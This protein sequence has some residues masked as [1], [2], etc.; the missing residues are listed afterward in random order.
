MEEVRKV[1]Q[2]TF[3]KMHQF[4]KSNPI[5]WKQ[6][7]FKACGVDT[8]WDHVGVSRIDDAIRRL[9]SDG[10]LICSGHR[11]GYRQYMIVDVSRV[12]EILEV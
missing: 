4:M 10:H 7:L 9:K 12:D 11:K 6:D 3:Q 5:F 8:S 2:D 1:Y